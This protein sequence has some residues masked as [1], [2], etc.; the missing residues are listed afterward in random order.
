MSTCLLN[1]I[2]AICP[3]LASNIVFGETIQPHYKTLT[4][5]NDLLD[6]YPLCGM[7]FFFLRNCTRT[8]AIYC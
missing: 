1:D 4:N 6:Q 8:D 5:R 2:T 7:R 3:F